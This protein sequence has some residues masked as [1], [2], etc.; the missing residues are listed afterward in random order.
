MP[1]VEAKCTN[2]GAVLP[3][4]SARDAWVCG[5]CGTPFVVEKAIQQFNITNNITAETVVVQGG[6]E[7]FE[8]RGGVLVKYHGR[9]TEVVV[10]ENVVEIG[11]RAFAGCAGLKSVAL[12]NTVEKI[13]FGAFG[14]CSRLEK[15]NFPRGIIIDGSDT[16]GCAINMKHLESENHH[17][18]Q[19]GNDDVVLYGGA[20]FGNCFSLKTIIL[21]DDVKFLY[22]KLHG[23]K[24]DSIAEK[25]ISYDIQI[26]NVFAGCRSLSDVSISDECYRRNQGDLVFI[27]T[28]FLKS[29]KQQEEQN[30]RQ[31]QQQARQQRYKQNGW[32]QHCGGK[33][34]KRTQACKRCGK[35]KDY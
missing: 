25:T 2:C 23:R 9:A 30:R 4:D 34:S 28:P 24:Y 20:T 18:V 14:F 27:G 10:P 21:P 35:P 15:I 16:S 1:F 31:Q 19:I 32:C 26:C 3:V 13:C 33:F 5:Y 12:P 29:R 8:I 7:D 6:K 22:G 17:H 11:A